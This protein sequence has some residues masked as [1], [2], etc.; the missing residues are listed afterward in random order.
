MKKNKT[1]LIM[2]AITT[3]IPFRVN[4][5]DTNHGVQHSVADNVISEQRALLEKNTKGAG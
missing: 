2:F 5:K 4:A 3:L 1:L